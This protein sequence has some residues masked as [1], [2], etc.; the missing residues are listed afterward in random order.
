MPIFAYHCTKCDKPFDV[1]RGVI[2]S[3]TGS[4]DCPDC[5]STETQRVFTLPTVSTTT[6]MENGEVLMHLRHKKDIEKKA[7]E[8]TLVSCQERGPLQFRPKFDK[9]IY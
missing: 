1:W 6:F 5:G 3:E 4:N 8:G 9:R 7:K 2:A